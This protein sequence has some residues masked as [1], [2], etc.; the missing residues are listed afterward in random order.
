MGYGM[1]GPEADTYGLSDVLWNGMI[2]EK[3]FGP[4]ADPNYGIGLFDDFIGFGICSPLSTSTTYF[5]SNGITYLGYNDATVVPTAAAVPAAGNVDH[6]VINL[7]ADTTDNDAAVIQ[8]GSGT[9]TPF[10]VIYGYAK[11]LVFET[12]F[13]VSAITKACTDIFIGLGGTG[14]CANSGVQTDD[15]ATLASNNFLGFVRKGE[16]TSG[17][18]LT[19]NRVS[20]TEE[21]HADV[22]T[23]V[24]DT[25]IKAGFRYHADTST[26]SVWMDGEKVHT[27][28]VADTSATPWPS[29]FMTFLAEAKYQATA[30]HILSIDWW[31]CAQLR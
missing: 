4:A 30:S 7:Q 14:A 16:A 12:R 1:N 29:L 10:N 13:K 21:A 19:Y 8:A 22:G 23:L 20:G 28:G 31:A 24:A 3:L 2:R 9:M 11:E 15:S 5:Q 17:L 6:G 18:S 26:L 27:V 25:F